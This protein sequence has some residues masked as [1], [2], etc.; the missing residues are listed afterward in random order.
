MSKR[1]IRDKEVTDT[2]LTLFELVVPLVVIAIVLAG[3]KSPIVLETNFSGKV[4]STINMCVLH[5]VNH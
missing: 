4:E 5:K 2:V 1:M 3:R